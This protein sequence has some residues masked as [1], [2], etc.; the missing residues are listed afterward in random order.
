MTPDER[1]VFEALDRDEINDFRQPGFEVFGEKDSLNTKMRVPKEKVAYDQ[2]DD[3][4]VAQLNGGLPALESTEP[5]DK[6]RK[7]QPASAGLPMPAI[8]NYQERMKDVLAM[9]E[10]AEEI[11]VE[12]STQGKNPKKAQTEARNAVD[13]G[14]L[15]AVFAN[16]MQKE[17]ADDQIGDLEGQDDALEDEEFEDYGELSDDLEGL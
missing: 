8:E 17:Y 13:Q 16:F 3:D 9:L 6:P 11:K 2:I 5:E 15:D 14:E 1:D 4:F 7:E 12:A 10:K